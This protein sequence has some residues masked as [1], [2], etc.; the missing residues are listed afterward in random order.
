MQKLMREVRKYVNVLFRPSIEHMSGGC[1]ASGGFSVDLR[2]PSCSNVLFLMCERFVHIISSSELLAEQ[3][4]TLL[5]VQCR[6]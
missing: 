6:T 2:R 1:A 3:V 5:G 4:L